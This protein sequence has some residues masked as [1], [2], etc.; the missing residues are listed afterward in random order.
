M[1]SNMTT[2][3]LII[4]SGLCDWVRGGHNYGSKPLEMTAKFGQGA[5]LAYLA[6]CPYW[7]IPVASI[8]FW[9]GEKPGWGYPTGYAYTGR[10][11]EEWDTTP[12]GL[13]WWQP[14]FLHHKPY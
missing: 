6:S 9:V 14:E 12:H 10:P 8:L 11:P 7:L 3:I 5:I 13:E 4:L 1:E 2:T